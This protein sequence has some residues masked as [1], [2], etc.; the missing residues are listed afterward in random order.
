MTWKKTVLPSLIGI[1]SVVLIA[2]FL[3]FD[4]DSTRSIVNSLENWSYDLQVRTSHR[5]LPKNG[6]IAIID[7]DDKSL[8]EIGKWPWPRKNFARIV[9]QAHQLGAKVVAFDFLFPEA[10]PNI[11]DEVTSALSDPSVIHSLDQVREQFDYDA[12]FAAAMQSQPS[13]LGF[14][15]SDEEKNEGILPP[16][17]L[18]IDPKLAEQLGI[19]ARKAFIGNI[20]VL[21]NAAQHAGFVN[22]DIDP[23]GVIRYSPLLYRF[24]NDLYASLA[25]NTCSV[26]LGAEK[27]ELLTRSYEG[28][29]VLEAIR[30]GKT[31]IP[32]DPWGRMLVPFRGPPFSFPYISATDLLNS[33]VAREKVE[34][35]IIFIGTSAAGLGDLKSTAIAPV[36]AGIEVHA[37]IASGIIDGYLPFNPTWGKG[38]TLLLVLSIGLVCAL[39]FPHLSPLRLTIVSL[40]LPLLILGANY[41][42]WT[43]YSLVLYVFFP[44]FIIWTLFVFNLIYGYLIES[45]QKKEIK[46]VF[47]QYVPPEY[48]DLIMKMGGK[49]NLDG[50][51]KVMTVLF[52]DIVG[53]TSVSEKMTPQQLKNTLNDYLTPMTEVIFN[54]K[55]TIDKYVGDMVVAFW[56]SPIEDPNHAFNG[57]GTAMDMQN[58]LDLVNIEFKKQQRPE[59]HIG[60]GV[61][62][63][64]MNVGDMGS[65]YRRAY[66]V[67]SDS[68]NLGS[69][70]ESLTRM[71][72][73]GIIIGEETYKL[74]KEGILFRT[75]DRVKVKGKTQPIDIYQ[76]ICYKNFQTKEILDELK[77]HDSAL[78]SYRSANWDEA[79]RLFK[80]LKSLDK[81]GRPNYSLFLDRIEYFRKNPPPPDWDGSFT[82]E[83]K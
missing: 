38:L 63:G 65:K 75:L 22:A 24:N 11:V 55:G 42:I 31:T 1:V 80:Q 8:A 69:R 82:F 33:R 30:L 77:L 52:A 68:V 4:A 17:F 41:F 2:C 18:S 40:I 3:F 14:V 53:F 34:N 51:S 60:I 7:I 27:G 72:E 59:I 5:P 56:G 49:L 32:V 16:P 58:R 46:S 81:P 79:E 64:V 61:N 78:A 26:Y 47:G 19:S 48:V 76:P 70:L 10:E 25:L 29:P 12:Q 83:H 71:Y 44:I 6:A 50:E 74:A 57:V 13:I 43:R 36:F 28:T 37:S 39:L 35:K 66:T 67:L 45:R 15:F 21:Q 9:Q 23:D 62:T 20:P 73:V 54:H